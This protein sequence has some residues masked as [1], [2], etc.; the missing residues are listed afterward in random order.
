MQKIKRDF[1]KQVKTSL[2]EATFDTIKMVQSDLN[3]V[4]NQQK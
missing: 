2:E 4:S 1:G 3:E